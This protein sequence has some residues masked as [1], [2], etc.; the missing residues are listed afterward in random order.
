M[1]YSLV[2]SRGPVL[3]I[4]KLERRS[5][6][7]NSTNRIIFTIS[8]TTNLMR[9]RNLKVC[10][11]CYFLVSSRYTFF[12]NVFKAKSSFLSLILLLFFLGGPSA[13]S[14]ISNWQFRVGALLKSVLLVVCINK[15][16]DLSWFVPTH[17]IQ[18]WTKC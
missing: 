5:Y 11:I 16:L 18:I 4:Y 14:S 2:S 6:L 3:I 17:L 9:T 15:E 13:I 7:R 1:I 8:K 10:F 12:K